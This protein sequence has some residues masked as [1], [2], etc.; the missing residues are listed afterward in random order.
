MTILAIPLCL[1]KAVPML[2]LVLLG[3]CALVPSAE[4]ISEARVQSLLGQV[5]PTQL[6]LVGE[7]HDVPQH[8]ALQ[9]RLVSALVERNQL[10]ALV[11]EMASE[12]TSTIGLPSGA[13]DTQVRRALQWEGDQESGWPWP[14]YGPVVMRAVRSGIPV[15]GGNL[16]RDT[17]RSAMSNGAL[18]EAL[19][20][21]ALARQQ[22]N[23]QQGHCGLL[24]QQ[25]IA[26]MTR[27]QIAR[28]QAM[29]RTAVSA[30]QPEKTVL[31]VAGNQHVRRDLGIPQHLPPGVSARVVAA[32][33]VGTEALPPD[34]ADQRWTSPAQPR[35]DYC[36]DL[37]R[38][39][40]R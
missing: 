10:A 6:L 21:Q 32:Q 33:A 18:D 38:Q 27:I 8:Q 19:S 4:V 12:G 28:D 24:P 40:N 5:L 35:R 26:P 37:K 9:A 23:I 13:S 25:Q 1:L 17:L 22:D 14:V 3:G 36:A 7:Q 29:A 20:P 2:S 15:L 31:L 34:Q 30:V 39:L 16:P 11:L